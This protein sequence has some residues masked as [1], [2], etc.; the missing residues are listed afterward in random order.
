[1]KRY[2]NILD[3]IYTDEELIKL[4]K[5]QH[6]LPQ[7][8]LTVIIPNYNYAKYLHQRIYSIL[9]QDIAIKKMIILDDASKD[10]SK[11]VIN[12]IYNKLNKYIDIEVLYN[13]VNSGSAFKQWEKGI[14]LVKTKYYWICEAD[15]YAKKHFLKNI[16]SVM[17]PD[18]TPYSSRTITIL[19]EVIFIS[20]ISSE[21]FLVS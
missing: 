4:A 8:D 18:V 15:D 9:K 13:E 5:R 2:K 12:N 11:E 17:R 6:K 3:G 21:T 20:I 1:M 7:E 16:F 10:D 14:N 19:T